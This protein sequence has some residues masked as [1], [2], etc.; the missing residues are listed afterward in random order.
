MFKHKNALQKLEFL[1]ILQII[2]FI[3]F[4]MRISKTKFLKIKLFYQ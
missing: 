2:K 3:M 4:S 1:N